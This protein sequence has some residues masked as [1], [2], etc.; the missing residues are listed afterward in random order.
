MRE[1][2]FKGLGCRPLEEPGQKRSRVNIFDAQ[3]RAY[4]KR[5]PLRDR[6]QILHVGRYPGHNHVCNFWW[7]SVKGF[8]RGRG[9][10][11]PFTHWLGSSPLQHS[12][13]TVRVCDTAVGAETAGL[14]HSQ[15]R[16]CFYCARIGQQTVSKK[17]R[18]LIMRTRWLLSGSQ[19]P[20]PLWFTQR[21]AAVF[22]TLS[23]LNKFFPVFSRCW[24]YLP[25]NAKKWSFKKRVY[26]LDIDCNNE[27]Y[28]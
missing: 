6:D 15:P 9:S 3:F 20:G 23:V 10:N 13:T 11:F 25:E 24:I 7:W 19:L 12:R 18:R 14:S 28:R 5:N 27:Y 4:G 8:G 26:F 2:L 21:G 16:C 1:N 22:L 17:H